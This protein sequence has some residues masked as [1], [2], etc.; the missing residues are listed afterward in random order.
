MKPKRRMH[1]NEKNT[2][3]DQ[4]NEEFYDMEKYINV[5]IIDVNK[6]NPKKIAKVQLP[7]YHYPI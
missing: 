1:L 4:Y 5:E 2:N 6:A 7:F 3:Y